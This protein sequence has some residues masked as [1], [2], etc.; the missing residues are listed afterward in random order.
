MRKLIFI[1]AA[2][3]LLVIPATAQAATYT[4]RQAYNGRFLEVRITYHTESTGIWHYTKY[5]F[6][7]QPNGGTSDFTAIQKWNYGGS[8]TPTYGVICQSVNI[9]T[10]WRPFTTWSNG[11][12]FAN[13]KPTKG[14]NSTECWWGSSPVLVPIQNFR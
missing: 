12:S 9:N 3:L 7:F 10:T 2:F 13:N 6:R 11:T 4:D 8:G 1:I 5:E 14:D